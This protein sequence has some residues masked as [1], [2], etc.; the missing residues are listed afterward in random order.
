MLKRILSLLVCVAMVLSMGVVYVAADET[1]ETLVYQ[2]M[3]LPD[4]DKEQGTSNVW[5][6]ANPYIAKRVNTWPRGTEGDYAGFKNRIRFNGAD[7]SIKFDF[8]PTEAVPITGFNKMIITAANA[9]STPMVVKAGASEEAM[10]VL[11]IAE[12]ERITVTA[13]NGDPRWDKVIYEVTGIPSDARYIIIG[14]VKGYTSEFGMDILSVELYSNAAFE[15]NVQMVNEAG[16][17]SLGSDAESAKVTTSENDP[18]TFY[19]SLANA[20]RLSVAVNK[21]DSCTGVKFFANGAE[22]GAGTD[23]DNDGVYDCIWRA[24]LNSAGNYDRTSRKPLTPLAEGV[25]SVYAVATYENATMRSDSVNISL[26]D[27]YKRVDKSGNLYGSVNRNEGGF[28]F[29]V[30]TDTTQYSKFTG[31]DGHD[32]VTY[33]SDSKAIKLSSVLDYG[34]A[35]TFQAKNF[36]TVYSWAGLEYDSQSGI[37]EYYFRLKTDVYN[38]MG[39]QLEILTG[40]T[41]NQD[42][43]LLHINAKSDQMFIGYKNTA[44]NVVGFDKPV[45]FESGKIYDIKIYYN[46]TN[47]KE[48]VYINGERITDNW[49]SLSK[50]NISTTPEV[51]GVKI[52]HPWN[53]KNK[54]SMDTY[55]YAMS[56]YQVEANTAPQLKNIYAGSSDSRCVDSGEAIITA[57]FASDIDDSKLKIYDGNELVG[58]YASS[59]KIGTY[60]VTGKAGMYLY[61]IGTGAFEWGKT[62]RLEIGGVYA[63]E[64]K[65]AA[66]TIEIKKV[67]CDYDEATFSDGQRTV[68]AQLHYANETGIAN[69]FAPIMAIYDGGILKT[70]VIGSHTAIKNED[71][72]VAKLSYTVPLE[73]G[74]GPFTF[75]I[76]AWEGLDNMMPMVRATSFSVQD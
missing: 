49:V 39:S 35:P 8:Q 34:S 76:L 61:G 30:F 46:H 68:N 20:I 26:Y 74:N 23:S 47:T 4:P 36:R 43:E 51:R 65:A 41:A 71:S 44:G 66:K 2:D 67:C 22:I 18:N 27:P 63:A 59:K 56:C 54:A 10:R 33:L 45:K 69:T 7:S 37:Y 31:A 13:A 15:Y 14:T 12:K 3:F 24:A 9:T 55:I 1:T 19:Y 40:G 21:P 53:E 38:N 70:A 73:F 58:E 42:V 62:Y 25:Y 64:M 48:L 52:T 32:D 6:A 11:N 75:N 16:C 57:E 5:L 50:A 72:G 17:Y 28:L 29:D 60:D